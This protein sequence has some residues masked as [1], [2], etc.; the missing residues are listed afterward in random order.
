MMLHAVLPLGRAHAPDNAAKSCNHHVD[1][2]ATEP[3]A[4]MWCVGTD[5]RQLI[6]F[7]IEFFDQPAV[8]DVI[9]AKQPAELLGRSAD[10]LLRGQQK[11]LANAGSASVL[12]ISALS[13]STIGAGVPLRHEHTEPLGHD[14]ADPR[15]LI[16]QARRARGGRLR[17]QP[18]GAGLVMRDQRRGAERADLHVAGH[19]VVDRLP[20]TPIGHVLELDAGSPIYLIG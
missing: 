3:A 8:F 16:G 20:S 14:E 11:V 2:T 18:Q 4:N 12:L 15:L 1:V 7:H 6:E 5:R 9:L 17:Q 19:Q 10:R 13:R